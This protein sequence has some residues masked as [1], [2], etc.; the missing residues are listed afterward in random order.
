MRWKRGKATKYMSEPRLTIYTPDS[1]LA[2]PF[3]MTREMLR[4][5]ASRHELACQL[6]V[7]DLSAQ[8]WQTFLWFL[9]VIIS[10]LADTMAWVF[11]SRAGVVTVVATPRGPHQHEINDGI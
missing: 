6:T 3:R 2:N 10:S 7:R 8:Y 5:L 9:W 4:D 11:L 1:L